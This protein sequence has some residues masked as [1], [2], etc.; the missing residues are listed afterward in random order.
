LFDLVTKGSTEF[1]EFAF[2]IGTLA[3]A[4]GSAIGDL[5]TWHFVRLNASLNF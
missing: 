5:N 1:R 4:R 3:A 2:P